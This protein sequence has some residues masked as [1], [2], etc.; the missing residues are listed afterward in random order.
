[1]SAFHVRSNVLLLA[2]ALLTGN[3]Y[4]LP[5]NLVPN[6]S[7]EAQNTQFTSDY[8]FT[9]GGNTAE[10][11]YTV[12][13][14]ST[15]WNTL[16][17]PTADHTSGAGY[18]MV[19]NG[20]PVDGSTVWK[21][22]AIPVSSGTSYF[23]EAFVRNVCC[24]SAYTGIN[25][26]AVLEFS[27]SLNGGPAVSLGTVTTDLSGNAWQGL[28]EPYISTGTGTVILSLINRNTTAGGNDF[29]IDDIYFGTESVVNPGPEG[30]PPAT[31]AIGVPTLSGWGTIVFAGLLAL[32]GAVTLR[33]QYR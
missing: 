33:R 11:Q 4:A 18:M 24:T 13:T 30:P 22:Q 10:G 8:A 21:S 26:P 7:F 3:A 12:S 23:F 29:A 14:S 16:F 17:I 6:G 1:M 32:W 2:A 9:P 31:G 28:S 25:S 20:S 5:V 15:P 27:V 19:A